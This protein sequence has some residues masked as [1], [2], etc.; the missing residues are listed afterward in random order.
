MTFTFFVPSNNTQPPSITSSHH[1]KQN[2]DVNLA[3][4]RLLPSYCHR[5]HFH[6]KEYIR[7]ESYDRS[8]GM[9]TEETGIDHYTRPAHRS[10]EEHNH[11]HHRSPPV[12]PEHRH[13]GSHG[14]PA[15]HDT[16]AEEILT[17]TASSKPKHHAEHQDSKFVPKK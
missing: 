5:S 8:K 9:S 13:H 6:S 1:F 10:T 7:S 17:T 11:H 3:A 4:S 15:H 14:N 12:E 16:L 2:A